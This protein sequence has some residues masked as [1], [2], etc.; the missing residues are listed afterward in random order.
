MHDDM[1]G[2]LKEDVHKS[3]ARGFFCDC[4][5]PAFTLCANVFPIDTH[6]LLCLD[7]LERNSCRI[8]YTITKGKDFSLLSK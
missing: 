6:S 8:Q 5:S 4:L 7:R 3:P 1:P 2:V